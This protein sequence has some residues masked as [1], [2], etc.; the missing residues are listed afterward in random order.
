MTKWEYLHIYRKRSAAPRGSNSYFR[1]GSNWEST[2]TTAAGSK[3]IDARDF[4]DYTNRLGED[5]WELVAISPRSG[6]LGG[7]VANISL[8]YAGFTSEEMW[9]F[10]RPRA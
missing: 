10:K 1:S 3:K 8:D 6:M 4:F 2:I 5:G 9:V 7:E